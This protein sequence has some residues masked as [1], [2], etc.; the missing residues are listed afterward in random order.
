MS[1]DTVTVIGYM[2]CIKFKEINLSGI[3]SV[4]YPNII[5]ESCLNSS[6]SQLDHLFEYTASSLHASLD[7][8]TP[9]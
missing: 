3:N 2:V 5:E 9:S 1:E 8:I 7:S 6:P 4:P